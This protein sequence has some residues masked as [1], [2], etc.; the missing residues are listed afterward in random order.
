MR[1]SRGD[2][3][4]AWVH[5]T[6]RLLILSKQTVQATG[7]SRAHLLG[8]GVVWLWGEGHMRAICSGPPLYRRC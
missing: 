2:E 4:V 5:G 3:R 6:S 1:N 7:A 8:G